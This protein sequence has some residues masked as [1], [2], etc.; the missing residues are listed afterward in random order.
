[1]YYGGWKFSGN[2][3]TVQLQPGIY[4]IAG[5]G[6]GDSGAA[7][8][9]DRGRRPD[10]RIPARVLIFSTDNTTDPDVQLDHR[11]LQAR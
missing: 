3:V 1:M 5:G 2:N 7:I 10:R 11:P 4:I 8:D 6:I 9:F